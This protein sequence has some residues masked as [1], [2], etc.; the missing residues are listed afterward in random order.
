MSEP[1]FIDRIEALFWDFHKANPEIYLE[2]RRLAFHLL[3]RGRTH[4]S[5]A[6]LF[7]VVRYN[8]A[9]TTTG[10]PYKVNNNYRALYARLLMREEP[11]LEGFFSLRERPS[12]TDESSL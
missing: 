6:G 8:R 11:K 7:E 2:L 4:Y 10:E 9:A 3:D 1:V 12:S 5:I